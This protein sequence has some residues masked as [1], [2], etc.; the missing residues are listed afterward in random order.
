MGLTS[1]LLVVY[2][3]SASAARAGLVTALM[4]RVGDVAI[5]L[6]IGAFVY[7]GGWHMAVLDYCWFC[8]GLLVIAGMTKSAQFPFCRWL[9]LAMAAPT[10]VS[11]LVH[12]STLVTA[13]VYLLVRLYPVFA[14]V[15]WVHDVLLAVGGVTM[16]LAGV[17]A[18]VD[19]DFKKVVAYSTLSQLGVIIVRLGL[20]LPGLSFFHLLAHAMFKALLFVCVGAV[21]HVR[22]HVQDVRS[23][24]DLGR[25]GP[26]VQRGMILSELALCGFPFLRG[27]YSKDVILE[28]RFVSEGGEFSWCWGWLLRFLLRLI[29]CGFLCLGRLSPLW[30]VLW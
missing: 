8:V 17:A 16:F 6:R 2:Y 7:C 15:V 19:C 13:G 10:P 3:Q 23:L 20:G 21:I 27:F 5:I 14:G 1:F 11:A 28:Q 9:P 4:N 12:S 25:R 18:F 30:G 24:G 22:G 26:F 29:Q